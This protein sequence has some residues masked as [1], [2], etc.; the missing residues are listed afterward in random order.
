MRTTVDDLASDERA[1]AME[2]LP[3]MAAAGGSQETG[4]HRCVR[5]MLHPDRP[6]PE[7]H[8]DLWASLP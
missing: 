1:H 5:M 6:D 2:N 4:L 7:N 3:R 8:D